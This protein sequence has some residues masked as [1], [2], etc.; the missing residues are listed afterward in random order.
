MEEECTCQTV[1][2]IPKGYRD[3]W[4]IGLLEV[5]WK[6]VTILL[7]QCLTMATDLHDTFHGFR[8]GR[9]VGNAFLGAKILQQLTTIS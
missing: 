3:F 6:T 2:L 4:V 7:N 5:L 1:V 8:S 9:G